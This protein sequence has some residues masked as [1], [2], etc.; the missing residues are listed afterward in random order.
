MAVSAVPRTEQLELSLLQMHRI[1][2]FEAKAMELFQREADPRLRAPVHRDGGDRRRRLL[3][4]RRDR[5]TSPRRTAATATRIAKGLDLKLMMAEITGRATGYCGGKGGSMH[6]TAMRHGMLGA[7]AIVAGSVAIAT[8]AAY[9][10]AAA[11]AG[12]RRRLVLRRRRVEPGHL[13][14]GGEPRR[15]SSPRRSSS[16]ARTTSGRSRC[17]SGRAVDGAGHRRSGR[18]A[19]ASRARS[20]TATT[21]FA[22]RE[23]AERAVARAR[24]GEGPTLIEAKTYRITPH[25]AATPTDNR[26]P[27]ELD[28]LALARSDRPLRRRA[29]RAAARSRR[30]GSPSSRPRRSARWRRRPI[31]AGLAVSGPGGGADGRL[32]A[33]RLERRRPAAMSERGRDA[34]ADDGGGAERGAARGDAPRRRRLRD[35]RGHR[36]ARRPV[37]GHGRAARRVRPGAGDR[38]ADLRGRAS[39]APA[40]APR[41]SAPG[42]SSSSRSPTSSR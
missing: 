25:S 3:G 22:V 14:R 23:A 15:R 21:C 4:A 6:I 41:S 10:P 42:R 32:R 5:T 30:R 17:R 34:R 16:S 9:A 39:P 11:G 27:E 8:G 26:P 20:S 37:Q 38:L 7:D 40:S 31:R 12:R 33:E 2:A 1:R 18:P 28:A 24:A 36:Q 29:R 13:P 19:T 35:R